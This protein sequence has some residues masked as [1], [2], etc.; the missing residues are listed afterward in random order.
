MFF[1][2]DQSTGEVRV[3]QKLTLDNEN[4]YMVSEKM[5]RFKM[6]NSETSRNIYT[7]EITQDILEI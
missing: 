2:V 6:M 3:A 7:L 4:I 5:R 1:K